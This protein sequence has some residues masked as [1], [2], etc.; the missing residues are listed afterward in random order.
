M[1][2]NGK[3]DKKYDILWAKNELAKLDP[4]NKYNVF[5][6]LSFT[7]ASEC[8]EEESLIREWVE[9]AEKL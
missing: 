7:K 5:L 1:V 6:K 3:T 2:S 9:Q 4:N 8:N